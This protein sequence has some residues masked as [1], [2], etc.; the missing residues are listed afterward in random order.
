M[1]GTPSPETISTKRKRI[2]RLA[3]QMPGVA[4]TSLS[5]H[6][7]LAWLKEAYGRTRKDGALGIDGQSAADY[8]ADLEANLQSLLDRA[9]SGDRYRAPAVR[10]VHI[11]K[12]DGSKTRPIGIPTFEDKVLQRAVVMALEPVFEQDFLDC[13]YGFRPGRSA[14]DALQAL[15][16]HVMRM[17]NGAWVLEGDIEGFFD[18]VDHAWLRRMFGERVRDGV[19]VRL[20][21]KWLN[22]GVM[23]KGSVYHPESGTP[24]GGVISPLLA[25]IYL[26][27]VLDAWFEREVKS[28]LR[29]R[30]HLV[31]YADDFVIVFEAEVDARRVLEVLPKRFGKHGLRLHPEKTR[32]VRFTKPRGGPKPPGSDPDH[33]GSFELL[34][35]RHF[36]GRSRKG[37]W[38]VKRKTASSRFSRTLHR[39]TD[40]CR[41]NRHLPIR[42]QHATLN[43]KLRGHDAYF[44]ITGNHRM[45]SA[46]R[47]QVE[48]VWRKWL[49]RRSR[50][51][52]L[53]W[54]QMTAL[55]AR[56][57]LARARVV[58]SRLR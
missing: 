27:E 40:W 7:D 43:A 57:P 55:L 19:L 32:L 56:H 53:T 37:Q 14:H 51:A 18:A 47:R 36:W 5:H 21:G 20:I 2:A 1:Q 29:G 42:E 45:L 38:V 50:K 24:Q 13:S 54:A 22:A 30:A 3:K 8:A 44:G 6:I 58:H 33:P 46:L 9:K 49:S 26:H 4:L 52:Q 31:R 17:P 28:R 10:R 39:F 34:G 23:E 35:F 12:G 16:E 15:W 25:N 48:R 41:R 11:P